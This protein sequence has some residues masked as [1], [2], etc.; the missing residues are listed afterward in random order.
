M[1]LFVLRH[2]KA[3]PYCPD[4]AGRQLV[5][6]GRAEVADVVARCLQDLQGVSQLWV[7]PLIRAQQTAA[8]AA[9]LLSNP[10]LITTQFL[11]PET[12]PERILDALQATDVQRLLLVSHQPLVSRLVEIL[13]AA[14]PGAYAMDTGSLACV[15]LTFPAAGL[16]KLRWLRHP[17]V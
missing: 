17:S 16:G 11:T 15:D 12:R 8:I 9:D 13:C 1:E 5:E 7:S 2:G 4:D 10:T 6:H 3:E 14:A